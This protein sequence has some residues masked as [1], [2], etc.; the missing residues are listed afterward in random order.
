MALQQG[1][2]VTVAVACCMT[3]QQRVR[4]RS[5]CVPVTEGRE[6]EVFEEG[7]REIIMEASGTGTPILPMAITV[8]AR[9]VGRALKTGWLGHG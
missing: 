2:T 1:L 9:E 3:A 7:R 4:L 6:L 5:G 8:E